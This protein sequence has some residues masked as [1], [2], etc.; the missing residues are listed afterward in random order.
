MA[1]KGERKPRVPQGD[2]SDPEGLAALAGRFIEAMQHL[3]FSEHTINHHWRCL[4]VFLAWAGDR[5]I[6]RPGEVTKPM[7]ERFQ[8]W[9]FHYRKKDGEALAFATQKGYIVTMRAWFKWLARHNH[10]LYTVA[11]G[12]ATVG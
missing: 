2:M 5:G 4:N 1:R 11:A 7:L 10:I 6:A 3:N 8:R 9:L 12:E